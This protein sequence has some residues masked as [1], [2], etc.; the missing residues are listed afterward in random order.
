LIQESAKISFKESACGCKPSILIVDDGPTNILAIKLMSEEMLNVK[1]DEANNGLVAVEQFQKQVNKKCRCDNRFY[2][3]IFMDI[4]MPE[5]NGIE[6][7]REIKKLMD[8][9]QQ[10]NSKCVIIFQ[11]AY[12]SS[13]NYKNC[14]DSGGTEVLNKPIVFNK[15]ANIL[16]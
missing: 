7:C 16:N 3:I 11:T 2:R 1:V 9:N 8:E 6:A 15:L 4:E 10:E 14:L 5:M 12:Y 13:K